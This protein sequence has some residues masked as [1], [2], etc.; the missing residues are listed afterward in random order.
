MR[1][2]ILETL[3]SFSF[4]LLCTVTDHWLVLIAAIILSQHGLRRGLEDRWYKIRIHQVEIGPQIVP[5]LVQG[6]SLLVLQ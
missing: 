5:P 4:F 2:S 1:N 6:R 3:A